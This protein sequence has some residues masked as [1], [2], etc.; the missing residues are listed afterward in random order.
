M[1]LLGPRWLTA[2]YRRQLEARDSI[3]LVATDADGGILGFC[4][5]G[6]PGLVQEFLRTAARRHALLI[7]WKSLV[8]A[9]VRKHAFS[10][11]LRRLGVR[12]RPAGPPARVPQRIWWTQGRAD[13]L[14]IGVLPETRGTGVAGKLIEAFR[15]VGLERGLAYLGL[16]VQ[17]DNTRAIAFYKKHGWEDLDTVGRCTR[18][19]LSLPQNQSPAPATPDQDE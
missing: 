19:G 5:G 18:F 17:S 8:H 2:L 9:P 3:S 6:R 12:P 11:L 4:V 14:S 16:T 10:Q 1:T 7:F 13:L 15:E